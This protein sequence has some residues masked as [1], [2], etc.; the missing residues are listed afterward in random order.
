MTIYVDIH[1]PKSNI[2]SLKRRKCKVEEK[3]LEVGDYVIGDIVIERKEGNDFISSVKDNR[4]WNQAGN[5]KQA[6]FPIICVIENNMWKTMYFSRS[7]YAHKMY[8]GAIAK[9]TTKYGIPVIT[10]SDEDD[11]LRF[12]ERIDKQQSKDKEGVRP[13]PLMRKATRPSVRLENSLCGAEGV[14]VKTSQDILKQFGTLKKVANANVEKLQ[15]IEG[16]GPKTAQNIYD[17]YH[18]KWTPKKKRK[19][20]KK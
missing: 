9:L 19:K 6:K 2:T 10:F 16:I 11:Y 1:E 20:N 13:A 12:L 15:N 18:R 7:R 4:L 5:L 3:Y 8:F 14:S 17:L